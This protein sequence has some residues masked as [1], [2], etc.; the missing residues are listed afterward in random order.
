MPNQAIKRI[1]D[2]V[3]N[4]HMSAM[5]HTIGRIA[6]VPV[7]LLDINREPLSSAANLHVYKF[8]IE[9]EPFLSPQNHGPLCQDPSNLG[10]PS[11]LTNPETQIKSAL[12]PI[13]VE[14]EHVSSWF[15]TQ[16]RMHPFELLLEDTIETTQLICPDNVGAQDARPA[17][18]YDREFENIIDFLATSTKTI[19][20]L[21]ATNLALNQ[22]NNDLLALAKQLDASLNAFKQFVDLTDVGTYMVDYET[23]ELLLYSNS[24]RE[25]YGLKDEECA[26][27]FCFHHM[28][29]DSFCPFCP[30]N[31]LLDEHAEPNAPCVWENYNP[32]F[33][34]WLSITSRALRWIDGRMVIMTSFFDITKRK[35]EEERIAYLAYHDQNLNI[36]NAVKLGEDVKKCSGECNYLLFLDIKALKD[37][38][39]VYGRDT[40]D[41]L[42]KTIANWLCTSVGEGI[43]V[44]RIA[45]D[46]FAILYQDTCIE[47]IEVFAETV[48]SR[49]ES[50]WIVDM[51]GVMQRVYTSAQLG[52]TKLKTPVDAN[53]SVL[54]LAEKVLL[55]AKNGNESIVFSE[56]MDRKY[57]EHSQLSVNLKACVLNHMEGFFIHYQPVVDAQT[58]Q[59]IGLEALC[60]W[61]S[62]DGK[63]VPPDIFIDEA[64]KIG[65][66]SLIDSWVLKQS[67]FQI[68]GLGLDKVSNFTLAV[69]LSPTQLRDKELA[70]FVLE[71]LEEYDFPVDKLSLE[72]TETAE[73]NFNDLTY[74]LLAKLQNAGIRLSLDDFGTGYATFSNLQNLPFN[75]LKTDRSFIN[76]IEDN[77]TL[78]QT[79]G[80]MMQFA[81][82]AGLDVTVEGV[83]TAEQYDIIKNNGA[84]HIQGFYFSR[85]LP[86]EDISNNLHMFK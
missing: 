7:V 38:N 12:I 47:E 31:S 37:I 49:F 10:K 11:I 55:F 1:N 41:G 44:Y 78:Q 56:E 64:E 33:D 70:T 2:L 17:N 82:L 18:V 75:T 66:V 22:K 61:V 84:N 39:T 85:P 79:M 36:A 26:G 16:I 9:S 23:G 48:F 86:L 42:L 65:I 27:S 20:H 80:I 76:G 60:R 19:T 52:I 30:R 59:W 25:G 6:C 45:G 83:E 8:S 5:Q 63:S 72:I 13:I 77:L 67:V 43:C 29:Y 4:E 68:K 53:F 34:A 62:P 73:I 58:C 71:V 50:P 35:K 54:N 32:K 40:G 57:Q 3:G 46:N 21:A 69:N 81:H 28:G 74:S 15:V 24:Y 14:G 51:D